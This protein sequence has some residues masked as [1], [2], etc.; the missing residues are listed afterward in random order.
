MFLIHINKNSMKIKEYSQFIQ[1][2]LSAYDAGEAE[3]FLS[4]TRR[5]SV[6]RIDLALDPELIFSE[7]N[8]RFGIL[9]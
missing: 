5:E 3:S 8:W 1:E 2:L 7:G 6:K 4:D 9:S